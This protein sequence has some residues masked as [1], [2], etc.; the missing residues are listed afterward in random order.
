[1]EAIGVGREIGPGE[2]CAENRSVLLL[3]GEKFQR[4]H[5]A[6]CKGLLSVRNS[7]PSRLSCPS[8]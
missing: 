5:P 1:M 7:L 6:R 8:N 3:G 2:G 4:C